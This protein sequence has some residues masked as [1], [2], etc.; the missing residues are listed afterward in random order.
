MQKR[1]LDKICCPV[2]KN[3]LELII[4]DTHIKKYKSEEIEEVL[5]GV[6]LSKSGW[7]YP[8]VGGVPRMQL[9]S[10]LDFEGMLREKYIEYEQKK[11]EI[12]SKYGSV[13][14]DILK[15]TK[16][17]R[18]SFGQ[19]WKIFKYSSD[20]TWGFTKDSRKQRFLKELSVEADSLNGKSL[21]DVGCGNGVLTSGIS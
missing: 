4:F 11:E 6:L 7:I 3:E 20:T 1:L 12:L 21:L 14:K 13:V 18:K 2:D 9:N 5:N 8:V 10:F 15:K 16:K 19:D 17:T